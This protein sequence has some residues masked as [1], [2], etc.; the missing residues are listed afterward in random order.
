MIKIEEKYGGQPKKGQMVRFGHYPKF[1]EMIDNVEKV[2]LDFVGFQCYLK[3]IKGKNK[4]GL[5]QLQ[6]AINLEERKRSQMGSKSPM[7]A[8]GSKLSRSP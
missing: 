2:A 3:D 8:N 1:S 6:Y 7:S 5:A 4:K